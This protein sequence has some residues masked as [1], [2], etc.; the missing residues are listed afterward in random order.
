MKAEAKSSQGL[1][2]GLQGRVAAITGAGGGMAKAM[3]DRFVE[4]GAALVLLSR[5]RHL[6]TGPLIA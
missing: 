4:L 3:L 6:W 1:D 2:Y 5:T